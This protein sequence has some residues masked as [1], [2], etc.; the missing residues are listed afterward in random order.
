MPPCRWVRPLGRV[1]L[2]LKTVPMIM[3]VYCLF[4]SRHRAGGQHQWN[5]RRQQSHDNDT[6][7]AVP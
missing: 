2:G 4:T 6:D 7:K 3:G 5:T 1:S